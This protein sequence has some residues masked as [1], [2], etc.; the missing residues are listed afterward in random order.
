M[1]AYQILDHLPRIP[2]DL[3]QRS[4]DQLDFDDFNR[5]LKNNYL[6]P[7]YRGLIKYIKNGQEYVAKRIL[8]AP[9]IPELE[10][11]ITD[12]ITWNYLKI[13]WGKTME[14]DTSWG[15]CH[16]PHTDRNRNYTL[17]YNVWPGG[18][19]HYTAYYLPKDRS[20]K[21]DYCMCFD[22]YDELDEIARFQ[23][24]LHT[25]TLLNAQMIHSI[26]C[27]PDTRLSIQVGMSSNP[28]ASLARESEKIPASVLA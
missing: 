24:P 17:V 9:V 22:N 16:P 6:R 1:I 25:W 2:E 28:F 27:V 12:N 21:V 18:P 8:K 4:L 20:I 7:Q 3:L 10:Q 15:D 13:E 11:W 26:E 23:A 19:D 14:D 5:A